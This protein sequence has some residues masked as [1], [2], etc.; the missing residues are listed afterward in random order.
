[1][2]TRAA[3]KQPSLRLRKFSLLPPWLVRHP[4]CVS[5]TGVPAPA[6]KPKEKTLLVKAK[7]IAKTQPVPVN[8]FLPYQEFLVGHLYEVTRVIAGEYSETQ[9]LVMHPA[10]IKLHEQRLGRWKIGKTYR[11][12]L[13]ELEKTVWKTVKSKDDSGPR[14]ERHGYGSLHPAG[15]ERRGSADGRTCAFRFGGFGR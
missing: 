5:W 8:E 6:E 12:Q 7:L 15:A 1:M 11:M 14:G 4:A 3:P 2:E 13:H 9:I 10:Y